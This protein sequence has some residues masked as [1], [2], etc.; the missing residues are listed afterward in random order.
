MNWNW[1]ITD[2]WTR[3]AWVH[4]EGLS[5]RWEWC[6]SPAFRGG[7]ICVEENITAAK[8]KRVELTSDCFEELHEF[9]ESVFHGSHRNL[10]NLFR[11]TNWK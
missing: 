2:D 5:I 11:P 10:E 7:K 1:Q 3:E 8:S 9:C 4:H 6:C